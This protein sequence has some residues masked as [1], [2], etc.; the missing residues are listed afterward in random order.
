MVSGTSRRHSWRV[1]PAASPV[2]KARTRLA[3]T[4]IVLDRDEQ[5]QRVDLDRIKAEFRS[6][7]LNRQDGWQLLGRYESFRNRVRVSCR[8]SGHPKRLS[9]DPST[10]AAILDKRGKNSHGPTS[11]I[12][13]HFQS[14][15]V[16]RVGHDAHIDHGHE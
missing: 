13:R 15:A 1:N 9:L 14:A 7:P 12:L 2:P 5:P 4:R 16:S 8:V 11:T 10:F 3:T 6:Q